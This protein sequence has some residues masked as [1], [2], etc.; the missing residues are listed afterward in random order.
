[1]NE[2]VQPKLIG[3][4]LSNARIQEAEAQWS[5]TSKY[6]NLANSKEINTTFSIFPMMVF[7]R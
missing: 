6:T 4:N 2:H 5:S 7:F 1:M 3:Q